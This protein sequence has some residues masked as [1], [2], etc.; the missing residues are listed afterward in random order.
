MQF[1]DLKRQQARIRR[2]VEANLMAVLDHGQYVMGPEI[3]RLE[4]RLADLCGVKHAIGC[5]SGTDALLM[6]LMASGI[7]YGDGVFTSPF[8]FIATAEAIRLVG[9]TPI[10]V[11]IEPDSFNIDPRLLSKAVKKA[12]SRYHH[13]GGEPAPRPVAI[14][15][16]DLFG[17]TANYDDI[18]AIAEQH[19]LVV[20][21]DAAQSFGAIYKG[22]WACSLA[23]VACTSF[24]PAKP[25]G[26]YGDGGMCFTDDDDLAE[27]LRSVR[28][29]GQGTDRYEHERIGINGRLDS[30]QAAVLLAKCDIFEA[31]LSERQQAAENYTNLL[32]RS[33]GQLKLPS[34][35]DEYR[36]AWAQYSILAENSTQRDM[37]RAK[38]Q[39]AGIPTA[40]YYPIPL[41]LQRAFQDLG[42]KKG[43]FPISEDC[44]RRIFS[45]PMHPYLEPQQQREVASA[46]NACLSQ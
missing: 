28:M 11:D 30:F 39:K 43:D 10:F 34:H 32:S 26:C 13:T 29:H 12:V 1:V 40:V 37:L 5:A 41:H 6:A 17:L 23:D 33:N 35:A 45:I 8:T 25:L 14:M 7:G 22:R 15:P 3:E 20:I 9:A 38:L 4:S 46:I 2:Q 24:F 44:C 42:Y 36:S 31:E 16:V 18:N 21:E 19:Q 27:K